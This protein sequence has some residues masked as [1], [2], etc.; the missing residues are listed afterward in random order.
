MARPGDLRK[1]KKRL[2]ARVVKR[3][4]TFAVSAR[5]ER[6]AMLALVT[7]F[8]LIAQAMFAN[9]A[10]AAS[11]PLVDGAIC[12][13]TTFQP[14]PDSGGS[15]PPDHDCQYCLSA[16]PGLATERVEASAPVTYIAV[17]TPFSRQAATLAPKARAPPRPPGQ[18]PPS[19]NA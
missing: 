8:A 1:A 5:A 17:A 7:V 3:T 9:L 4:G 10:M 16:R 13:D 14:S 6:R 19:P 12:A 18:G 11:M 15:A 2:G